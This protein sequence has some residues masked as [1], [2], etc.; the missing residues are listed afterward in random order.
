MYPMYTQKNYI[1]VYNTPES[2][3]RDTYALHFKKDVY[4]T[5]IVLQSN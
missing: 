5:P 3:L 1:Y 4:F 2:D